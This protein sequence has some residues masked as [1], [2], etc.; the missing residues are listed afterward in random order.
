MPGISEVL[1][2]EF[3]GH[4][5]PVHTHDT[6]TVLVVDTG[7]VRYALDGREQQALGRQV[8]VLPPGVPHDGRSASTRPFRKRVAYL[9]GGL[10]D[11]GLVGAAVD[12]P[13]S[14]DP[15]L[16]GELDALHRALEQPGD[17]FEGET[18]L[19]VVLGRLRL[20]LTGSP[21]AQAPDR[22]LARRL[23]TLLD[24]HLVPGISL[25]SAASCLDASPTHLVRAFT[26]E[27][28]IAPHR[29]L[30]GRR[31]DRAR[32]LLLAGQPVARVATDVGF[33][34][35]AHLSRHFRRLLGVPPAAYARSAG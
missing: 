4:V 15:G 14:P 11:G 29:Y 5:Y 16:L 30:T 18:R 8:T 2:A 32:R 22:P 12:R 26:A 1:H 31:L 20:H 3:A 13:C 7:A 28:G 21:G 10:L 24:E 6:W 27:Y 19:A 17:A 35:Q 33:D 34:D 25:A 9:D 23:R